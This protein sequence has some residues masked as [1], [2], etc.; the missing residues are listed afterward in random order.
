[1]RRSRI[2]DHLGPD[3]EGR[4]AQ[5]QPY[6]VTRILQCRLGIGQVVWTPPA[7]R[8]AAAVARREADTL[9]LADYAQTWIQHRDL[10]PRTRIAYTAALANH[11]DPALEDTPLGELSAP[12]VRAGPRNLVTTW[13]GCD[14]TFCPIVTARSP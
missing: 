10:K 12:A 9:T 8:E 13:V 2:A 5:H 14:A 1:M 3:F 7:V 4:P 11:I 6:G